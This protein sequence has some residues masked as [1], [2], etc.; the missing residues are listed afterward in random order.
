MNYYNEE[1]LDK[2]LDAF[3]KIIKL[4]FQHFYYFLLKLQ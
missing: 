2:D 1:M 3:C 4:I